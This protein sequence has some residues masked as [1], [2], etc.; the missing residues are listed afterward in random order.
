[1]LKGDKLKMF[2]KEIRFVVSM[3]NAQRSA[4]F[5]QA[6]T[7]PLI[8][9]NHPF[10]TL[11]K[12]AF[13]EFAEKKIESPATTVSPS[14]GIPASL[15]YHIII[16]TGYAFGSDW[17]G[18]RWPKLV[19]MI[20][21]PFEAAGLLVLMWLFPA[22]DHE[23]LFIVGLFLFIDFILGFM[24]GEMNVS[25]AF[26]V[27]KFFGWRVV[28]VGVYYFYYSY[29]QPRTGVTWQMYVVLAAVHLLLDWFTYF[30][31][32]LLQMHWDIDGRIMRAKRYGLRNHH[33]LKLN[34]REAR[35]RSYEELKAEQDRSGAVI[36]N[37]DSQIE[38]ERDPVLKRELK[39]TLARQERHSTSLYHEM[40]TLQNSQ[41]NLD[42]IFFKIRDSFLVD[43]SKKS[44]DDPEKL[45]KAEFYDL[46][47]NFVILGASVPTYLLVDSP[48]R[49][50]YRW[51]RLRVSRTRPLFIIPLRYL[52]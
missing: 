27:I 48:F 39:A 31:N 2:E 25:S 16:L 14:N 3:N 15:L 29:Q 20:W 9:L 42:K 36:R 7:I 33:L 10:V 13:P 38:E 49:S 40:T 52:D 26:G 18:K 28:L 50:M 32:P 19:G 45:T 4:L 12:A 34:A 8:D 6:Q 47:K 35:P 44:T 41:R 37:L 17:R 43:K 30:S 46:H 21:I 23:M 5:G 22:W 1:L 51:G 11:V 24:A